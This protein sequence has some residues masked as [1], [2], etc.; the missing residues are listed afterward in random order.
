MKQKTEHLLDQAR[1]I[2]GDDAD[3]FIIAHKKD[4]CG[5]V[6]HGNTDTIAQAIFSCMHNPGNPI[7]ATMYRIIKL[8]V[9][10][11]LKSP[12]PYALDLIDTINSILPDNE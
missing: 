9:M 8:N 3:F 6:A 11:I 10:N 12:S 1:Q 7:G 2:M 5:A 4:K